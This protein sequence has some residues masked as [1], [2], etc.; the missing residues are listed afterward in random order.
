MPRLSITSATLIAGVLVAALARAQDPA[1]PVTGS[2]SGTLDAVRSRGA[3][4]CGIDGAAAGFSLPDSRGIM[5]GIDADGCR[6]V[7][8]AV[9]GD[10]TR[11]RFVPLTTQTRFTALQSG[12]VDV[13]IR[14]TSWTL[15]R[16]T[17]L[18]LLFAGIDFYDSTGFLV[19]AASGVKSARELDGATVCVQPGTSTELADA[20]YFRRNV[21]KFKPVEVDTVAGL[22]QTFLSGGCSAISSESSALAGFRA[23]QGEHKEDLVLLPEMISKEPLGPVV[24]KGDDK[25]LDL[26]RWT[27][28]AL[29]SAEESGVTSHNVDSF[30]ATTDPAIR[31]LLGLEGDLGKALGVDDRW[32]ATMIRQVGNSGEIWDRG[33]APLGIPRGL[34]NLW[35][36]GG[37][38]YPPPIR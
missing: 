15:G 37:L 28:F 12:E 25:W 31:R 5:Q 26:V 16:E 10:A 34:N 21:M 4:S 19:T 1:A 20:D 17:N 32:A 36:H 30:A 23:S 24:R 13:L 38:L 6:A 18:G 14:E 8:A 2:G 33:I 29:A 11:V 3:L 9:L 35:N 7:A 22:Q 27:F